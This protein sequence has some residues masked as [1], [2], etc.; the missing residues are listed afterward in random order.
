MIP[1][2]SHESWAFCS[3]AASNIERMALEVLCLV[4]ATGRNRLR[5]LIIE[6]TQDLFRDLARRRDELR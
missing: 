1:T 2:T 3:L 6:A 4:T 5:S